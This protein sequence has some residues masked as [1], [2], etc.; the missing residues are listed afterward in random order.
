MRGD[1]DAA[2]LLANRLRVII[3]VVVVEVIVRT[4]PAFRL[5]GLRLSFRHRQDCR[6]EVRETFAD[7]GA[8]LDNQMRPGAD[9]LLDG[10]SH[11]ELLGPRL[12]C[13]QSLRDVTAVAKNRADVK[14]H[15]S[16]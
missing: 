12:I 7:A 11:V 5:G 3:I 10:L 6:D 13:R 8:G 15:G 4:L 1:D 16:L 9:R 14:V 2:T